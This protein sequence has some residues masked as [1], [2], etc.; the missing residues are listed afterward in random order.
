MGKEILSEQ[1]GFIAS[2]PYTKIPR[3]ENV[4]LQNKIIEEI[5]RATKLFESSFDIK[6]NF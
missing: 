4:D 2:A 5:H 3:S 1:K 6:N